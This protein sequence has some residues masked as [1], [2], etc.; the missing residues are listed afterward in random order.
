MSSASKT[1]TPQAS[2]LLFDPSGDFLGWSHQF[3]SHS[4]WQ[5]DRMDDPQMVLAR[6]QTHRA[7]AIV[8]ASS[9][10]GHAELNILSQVALTRP[11]MLRFQLGQGLDGHQQRIY[12]QEL[13]HRIFTHP[14]QIEAIAA[15]ITYLRK[16][17]RLITRPA[18]QRYISAHQQL[19][20]PPAVYAQLTRELNSRHS[21]AQQIAAIIE[22]DPALSARLLQQ[23]NSACFALPRPV[24]RI[25]EAVSL[26]GIRTLRALALSQRI[27]NS[28]PSHRNWRSFS[29]EKISQRALLVARLAE[30]I[31][32]HS[33]PNRGLGDQAFLA[34]LLQDIGILAMAS[35]TPA[36]YMKVLRLAVAENKSLHVAEQQVTGFYHGEVGAALMAHWKL[37]PRVVEAIL[38]HPAPHLSQHSDFQPLTAAHVADALLPPAWQSGQI[39][40]SHRLNEG[41]LRQI[42]CLS[43][44]HHWKL[45]AQEYRQLW[46]QAA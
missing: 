34:G 15:T 19:P 38:F 43:E 21:S 3:A 2:L 36:D 39:S 31:C 42:G 1:S 8:V 11:D 41:Y 13:T 32:R 46:K 18:L 5:V 23:V 10:K 28:Y 33:A 14:G 30:A 4:G 44:L 16:V 7:S 22:Q 37:P 9:V 27:R 6:L 29:F 26:L 45:I 20:T 24:S 17:Q 40:L 35:Q 12:K 25:S